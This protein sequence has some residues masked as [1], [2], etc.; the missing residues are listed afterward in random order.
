MRL[1]KATNIKIDY[2]SR[3]A[4]KPILAGVGIALAISACSQ[5]AGK[6]PVKEQTSRNDI[7]ESLNVAGGMPVHIPPPPKEHN[8]SNSYKFKTDMHQIEKEVIVAPKAPIYKRK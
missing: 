8:V 6:V 2:P 3:E 1:T 4:I 7:N 5:T